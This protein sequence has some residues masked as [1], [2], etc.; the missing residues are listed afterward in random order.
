MCL[1]GPDKKD[2]PVIAS[3]CQETGG[4]Q[5]W[6]YSRGAIARDIYCLY[7]EDSIVKIKL[8]ENSKNDRQWIY[9]VDTKQFYH[10]SVNK[11][12]AIMDSDKNKIV[13][14]DCD[15]DHVNQKWNLQ[16]LDLEKLK[17]IK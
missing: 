10:K 3:A 17:S 13:L 6:E 5:Y 2:V 16:N 7:Y 12:L 14:S 1:D 11:C 4:S 15:K 8:I 9:N